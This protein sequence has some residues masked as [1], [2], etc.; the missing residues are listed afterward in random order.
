MNDSAQ[1]TTRKVTSSRVRV[2]L[3][4]GLVPLS[5][6]AVATA[7]MVSWVPELPEPIAVHWNGSGADGFGQALPFVFGPIIITLLFTV[8]TLAISWKPLPSGRLLWNQKI[9]VVTNVWLAT[10]LAAGF[11][12][13]VALQRGIADAHNAP[14]VG[15]SLAAGAGLGILLAVAAW[16]A[17]PAGESVVESVMVV[18]PVDVHGTERVSWTHSTKM[19]TAV[20]IFV[21]VAIATGLLLVI[22]ATLGSPELAPPG[23][24]FL[25]LVAVLTLTTVW[26]RVSADHRGFMVKGL[27]GWPRKHIAVEDIRSAAVV[28]V[29]P[30]RDF[31]GWGWRWAGDGRSG[32]ILRTGEGIEVTHT[33]GKR[34]VVTVDDA[35]TGAGVLAA[36]LARQKS[37]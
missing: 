34:F 15:P 1:N 25:A 19:G 2:I 33:N 10:L 11:G 23:F 16:F 32:I 24:V 8:F 13:S 29:N 27:F 3:I 21:S 35:K 26:W 18:E 5:I 7:L 37:H 17:L 31:G 22:M 28:D 9:L 20:Q 12:S 4:G 36:L 6:A 30:T 14:G